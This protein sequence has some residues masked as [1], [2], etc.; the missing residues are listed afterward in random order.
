MKLAPERQWKSWR[1]LF[2]PPQS[3]VPCPASRPSILQGS[4]GGREKVRKFWGWREWFL[5]IGNLEVGR[6][7]PKAQKR[8]Q[9]SE[10]CYTCDSAQA[11]KG[12]SSCTLGFTYLERKKEKAIIFIVS[13]SWKC[14]IIS[15]TKVGPHLL[16]SSVKTSSQH[17]A[18]DAI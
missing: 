13:Q 15:L 18:P 1:Y 10:T 6:V 2:S 11:G 14:F 3:K 5:A 17:T 4:L 9:K 7:G 16:P 8:S 12:R